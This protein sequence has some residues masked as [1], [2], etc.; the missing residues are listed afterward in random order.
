MEA[1]LREEF[2][3]E[4]SEVLKRQSLKS[5]IVKKFGDSKYS[6][7]WRIHR[8]IKTPSPDEIIYLLRAAS[9]DDKIP[10]YV[11]KF[12]P[13]FKLDAYIKENGVFADNEVAE[14]FCNEDYFKIL[15][16]CDGEGVSIDKIYDDYG[17]ISQGS[18]D[19]LIDKGFI[20]NENG[21]LRFPTD[22]VLKLPKNAL[23]KLIEHLLK[24]VDYDDLTSG[25]RNCL[26]RILMIPHWRLEKKY[27]LFFDLARK[28][29]EEC[30]LKGRI[31]D[32]V[33]EEIKNI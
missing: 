15:A 21:V 19:E 14:A 10:Y 3:G 29:A 26:L 27:P 5:F 12:H 25:E 1:S 20:V 17:K 18:I 11:S 2:V 6:N 30:A 33:R 28:Y 4:F 22:Q 32:E 13:E 16:Q 24:F 8:G 23:M 7:Y 31:S 9:K